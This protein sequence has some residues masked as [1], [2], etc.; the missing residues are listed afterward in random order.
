MSII[1]IIARYKTRWNECAKITK[2]TMLDECIVTG[3]SP[4][5]LHKAIYDYPL[6][7]WPNHA[8]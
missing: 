8:P 7:N 4:R 2:K 5:T 3:I 1:D 6:T